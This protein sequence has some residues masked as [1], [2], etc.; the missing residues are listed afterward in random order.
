MKVNSQVAGARGFT[1]IELLVV[2]AII[3]IL[4]AILLPALSRAREA[5][6]RASCQNN[7]KQMGLVFKMFANESEGEKWPPKTTAIAFVFEPSAV[8]PEYL[9]DVNAMICP[10][11]TS[12]ARLMDPNGDPATNWVDLNGNVDL[13][14]LAAHGDASYG[15]IGFAV[16]SNT[17]LEGWAPGAIEAEMATMFTNPDDDFELDHPVLGTLQVM[18]LR[19]GIERFF[20]SDINNPA[21][22][23]KAQSELAVYFDVLS[24]EVADF[25]HVPGGCNVLFMDGHVAF[26][27][28]PSE[29]F[30]VTEEFAAFAT[31]PASLP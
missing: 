6:R 21:A 13:T 18:R 22:S 11:D 3:G 2:I 23:N 30:P 10:S 31:I 26:I 7:L 16:P 29:Q 28:Y 15:Y 24:T 14:K 12:A 5:A 4:A 19:E 27:R 17:W 1:L 9:T 25:S 20:I 8:Y